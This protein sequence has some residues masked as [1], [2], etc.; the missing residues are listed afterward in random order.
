MV[1]R[2]IILSTITGFAGESIRDI[3]FGKFQPIVFINQLYLIVT[4]VT[5]IIIFIL[6]PS[7][8]IYWNLFFE[9]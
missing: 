7:I 6:Y 4:V 8:K 3:I 5:G 2:G 1:V 9:I